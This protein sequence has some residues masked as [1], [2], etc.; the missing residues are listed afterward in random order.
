VGEVMKKEDDVVL[1]SSR[2]SGDNRD[3]SARGNENP[4]VVHII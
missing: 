3:S 2:L 4:V 1:P